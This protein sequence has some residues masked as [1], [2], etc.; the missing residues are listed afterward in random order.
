LSRCRELDEITFHNPDVVKL[1]DQN[2]VMIQVDLTQK[3]NPESA[4][5][6]GQFAI[7]GVPT[8][9]FLDGRGNECRNLRLVD[10]L[11]PEKMLSRMAA[12]AKE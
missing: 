2:F 8:V 3:G 10:Y 5:L 11:P 4:R 6:L 7:K 9:V 12:V 1:A